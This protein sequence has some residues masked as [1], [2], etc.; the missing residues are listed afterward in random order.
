ME[1]QAIIENIDETHVTVEYID[2]FGHGNYRV[3]L[4]IPDD[5]NLDTFESF[6][7]RY[8]PL[9][10]LKKRHYLITRELSPEHHEVVNRYVGQTLAFTIPEAPDQPVVD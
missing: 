2:P 10:Y 4:E 5:F 9:P 3:A 7:M 1:V 6:I 8:F